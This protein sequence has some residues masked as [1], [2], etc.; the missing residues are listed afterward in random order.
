MGVLTFTTPDLSPAAKLAYAY[1]TYI[2]LMMVYSANNLPYSALSGVMTGDVAER[3]SLSQYRFVGAML[4][5]LVIQ[6]L[7]LPMVNALGGGDD[8][9]G[10]RLTMT[11]FGVLAAVFFVVTFATTRERILPAPDQK[12]SI[13]QDFVDLFK[14]GPWLAMFVLTILLFVTLALRGGVML[15]YFKYFVRREDL[16][17]IFNLFG[18]GA[19]IV[20]VILSKGLA[21]RYGKR[22]LFIAG[23]AGTALCTAA[24]VV[25]PADAIPVII[26]VEALRQFVYGF[27]IPL[28]WAMMADVADYSEWV[29]NRR[30]TAVVFSAI[31]FGLKA[32]LGIGGAIGGYVLSAYGYVPNVEQASRALDGIRMSA[33]LF[34]ALG[35]LLCGVCLLFYRIDRRLENQIANDLLARRKQFTHTPVPVVP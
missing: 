12:S 18:T 24:F 1:A 9:R 11:V 25:L 2:V 29:N 7:A 8:A 28:L 33:S 35:F 6:S 34:P 14:N 16:F 10:Y 13:R 21:L 26:G 31:V 5:Q 32:G 17:S 23:L 27:T 4:S 22:N 15:Y 20:G 30:A 3:T 19:T